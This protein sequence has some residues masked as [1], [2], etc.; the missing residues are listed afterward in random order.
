[1]SIHPSASLAGRARVLLM[2]SACMAAWLWCGPPVPVV[3]ALEAE[4][5]IGP[6]DII[7]V[8]VFGEDDLTV[9]RKVG[10][11]G[12]INFPLL[13]N[14]VV[15]GRTIQALQDELTTKLADGFVRQ[16]KVIAYIVRYRNFYVS[17]EVKT[18]GGYAYE[19]GLTVQ[20]A[21]SLAGGFTE[22]ADRHVG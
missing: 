19:E 17:G 3:A 14:I 18:P 15:H 11:D 9:E 22:K 8:Q 5:R 16:P 1:M 6:N 13:G 7:R 2:V 12:Q 4:Y 21:I 10:G 20:K